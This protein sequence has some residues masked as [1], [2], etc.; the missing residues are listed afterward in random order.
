MRPCTVLL[1]TALAA[2][3]DAADLRGGVW[4]AKP[5]TDRS[6]EPKQPQLCFSNLHTWVTHGY[7]CDLKDNGRAPSKEDAGCNIESY[8]S[9]MLGV[10]WNVADMPADRLNSGFFQCPV[11]PDKLFPIPDYC[12]RAI[13]AELAQIYDGHTRVA[14]TASFVKH[15]FASD[16]SRCPTKGKPLETIMSPS[17]KSQACWGF[18]HSYKMMYCSIYSE[19]K[20]TDDGDPNQSAD[21]I[22]CCKRL[23]NN[24]VARYK[25]AGIYKFLKEQPRRTFQIETPWDPQAAAE[26][27]AVAAPGIVGRMTGSGSDSKGS[28]GSKSSSSARSSASSKFWG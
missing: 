16:N 5:H 14:S 8:T 27:K 17:K 26:A 28:N 24:R 2:L 1:L 10:H 11:A 21:K 9:K 18:T 23:W 22:D 4:P 19:C 20:V 15:L 25:Q 12:S 7:R 3:A 6:I 13:V